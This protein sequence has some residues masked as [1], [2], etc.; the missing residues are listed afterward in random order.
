M[1]AAI[2]WGPLSATIGGIA[3][4]IGIGALFGLPYCIALSLTVA[5]PAWWLGHLAMLGRPV[6][7][8]LRGHARRRRTRDGMVS[9]RPPAAVDR[10][11][12]RAH[13][14]AA[15]LTLGTDAETSRRP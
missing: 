6:A 5:L 15:L 3:A 14:D 4:A 2:G 12:R 10:R 11:L 13:H 9:G 8:R 1:V 7:M